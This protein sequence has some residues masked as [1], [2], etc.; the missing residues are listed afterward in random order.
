METKKKIEKC[1]HCGSTEGFII[2]GCGKARERITKFMGN[3]Q[4]I[5]WHPEKYGNDDEKDK[6]LGRMQPQKSVYCQSETIG[7]TKCNCEN[8]EYEAGIVLDPFCGAGT[9]GVVAKR[10]GRQFLDRKS[11]V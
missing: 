10:L 5:K 11:V 2:V 4:D 8:P 7:W 9:T 3:K 6:R 1:P